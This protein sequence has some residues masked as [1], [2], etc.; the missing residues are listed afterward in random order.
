MANLTKAPL[1]KQGLEERMHSLT[2]AAKRRRGGGFPRRV[3]AI[4]ALGIAVRELALAGLKLSQWG[5]FV[6]VPLTGSALQVG[7]SPGSFGG[8]G[9]HSLCYSPR[10]RCLKKSKCLACALIIRS[11]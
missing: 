10:M 3:R 7:S 11:R 5:W 4:F 8:A 6:P 1:S 2:L 9:E